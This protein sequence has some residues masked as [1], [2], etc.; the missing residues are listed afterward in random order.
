MLKCNV[1]LLLFPLYV[2]NLLGLG[3]QPSGLPPFVNICMYVCIYVYIVTFPHSLHR[4]AIEKLIKLQKKREPLLLMFSIQSKKG[5][6]IPFT[7][8]I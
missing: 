2:S 6:T 4:N 3:F 5:M 8:N 7:Q 1:I